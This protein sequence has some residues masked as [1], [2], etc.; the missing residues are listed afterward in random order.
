MKINSNWVIV[1]GDSLEYKSKHGLKAD[2]V[3]AGVGCKASVLVAG[4]GF[5]VGDRI[6]FQANM[7]HQV[8][9]DVYC[10][11]AT[12]IYFTGDLDELLKTKED[13]DETR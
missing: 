11:P 5:E 3:K 2:L 10:V 8:R 9:K 7:G 13:K 6:E 1:K 4:N 12:S